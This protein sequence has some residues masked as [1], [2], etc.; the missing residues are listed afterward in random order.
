MEE[1]HLQIKKVRLYIEVLEDHYREMRS[2]ERKLDQFQKADKM[3]TEGARELKQR[4][5]D[6][7]LVAF[8]PIGRLK[9][10]SD[11]VRMHYAE[12]EEAKRQLSGNLRLVVPS[13]RSTATAG[14]PSSTSSRR[15]T[16]A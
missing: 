9:R 2:V 10:R 16:P 12:Y 15:A 13:R 11:H 3:D 5:E 6:L 8:E 14:S 7:E 4:L 1:C